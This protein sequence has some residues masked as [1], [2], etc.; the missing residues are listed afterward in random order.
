MGNKNNFT[1]E[2][3]ILIIYIILFTSVNTENSRKLSSSK[4]QEVF[5]W[6]PFWTAAAYINYIIL[7]IPIKSVNVGSR[8]KLKIDITFIYKK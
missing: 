2:D 7:E 3:F 5:V 8:N 1:G 4:I 6:Q